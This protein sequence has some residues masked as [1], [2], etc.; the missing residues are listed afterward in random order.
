[1]GRNEHAILISA[2]KNFQYLENLIEKISKNF[3]VYV[4]VD[5]SSKEIK[6]EQIVYLENKYH[7][8]CWAKY[9]CCW[10]G[11]NVLLAYI[12]L[13]KESHKKKYRYYHIISGEDIPVKSASEIYD[14]FK[15]NNQIYMSIHDASK[16]VLK[17]RYKYWYFLKNRDLRIQPWK[18]LNHISIYIQKSL[19]IE[20]KRIGSETHIYKGYVYCSLPEDAVKYVIDYIEKNS[21]FMKDISQCFIMEE[22]FFQTILGNSPLKDRISGE[23]LRYSVWEYKHGSIPG[24]LDESDIHSIEIGNYIFARKVN[25]IYSEKLIQEMDR[26]YRRK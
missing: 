4:H 18:L 25:Y 24:Y 12:D 16:R 15:N 11:Y 20:R 6:H 10:G 26:K 9:S 22:L 23:C 13:L 21:D 14:F 5:K 2:Y 3:D 17:E 7:C 1:M 8:K 19:K